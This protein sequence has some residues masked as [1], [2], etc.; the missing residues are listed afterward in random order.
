V[1][2]LSN[3]TIWQKLSTMKQIK[4]LCVQCLVAVV[5]AQ[6]DLKSIKE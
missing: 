4:I 3:E 6:V 5:C 2:A 1:C